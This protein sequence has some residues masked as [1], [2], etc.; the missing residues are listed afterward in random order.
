MRGRM[1]A[2]AQQPGP[3]VNKL[4]HTG[5]T[6]GAQRRVRRV[7]GEWWHPAP[8]RRLGAL[9]RCVS[10]CRKGAQIVRFCVRGSAS[11]LSRG[12]L[13]ALPRWRIRQPL[14]VDSR[15]ARRAARRTGS[16]L[17]SACLG[18]AL[19]CGRQR[20]RLPRPAGQARPSGAQGPW[21]SGV[22][23]APRWHLRAD[24]R[25]LSW[26]ASAPLA[27]ITRPAH[28]L[29]ARRLGLP[30]AV[31]RVLPEALGSIAPGRPAGTR[32]IR[33]LRPPPPTMA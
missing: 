28:R 31:I 26:P 33:D 23:S 9:G 19:S 27:V 7:T 32:A 24:W 29:P 1:R 17:S 12:W 30:P 11:A 25:P 4:A 15:G 22:P 21:S 13:A 18:P 10:Y 5:S 6:S 2:S 20:A 16:A 8:D 14:G 3:P